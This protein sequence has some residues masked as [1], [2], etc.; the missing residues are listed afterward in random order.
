[1]VISLSKGCVWFL[2]LGEVRLGPDFTI[3]AAQIST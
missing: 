1:M 2:S 3:F